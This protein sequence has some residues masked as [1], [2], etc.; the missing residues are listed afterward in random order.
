[1]DQT[2]DTTAP[3]AH[4]SPRQMARQRNGRISAAA[5]PDATA[6]LAARIDVLDSSDRR[7]QISGN[8]QS[9][10]QE[11][12]DTKR[13]GLTLTS[14]HI[15]RNFSIAG[16]MIRKHL[17]FVASHNFEPQTG[18]E[19]LDRELENLV[20]WWSRPENCDAGGR[21]PLCRMVRL[22]EACRTLDGDLLLMKLASGKVQPIEGDRIKTPGVDGV[23]LRADG[24]RISNGVLLGGGDR[25]QAWAVHRRTQYGGLEFERWVPNRNV[26]HHGYF[27]RFDQVRG[28]SPLLGA[29]APLQ[30][31]YE[32]FT[33]ALAK[34]KAAQLF[35]IAF[36][37]EAEETGDLPTEGEDTDG[38][39]VDDRYDVT[40]GTRPLILDLDPGDRA[41]FLENKT[42]ATEFQDFNQAMIG[43][44]LKALDIPYSFYDE[45]YTNFF[46]SMAAQKLYLKSARE[47]RR[48]VQELL[49]KLTVWRL[50][51]FIE[52]GDLRLPG[53]KT[54]ADLRW[55]WIPDG[56]P[57]FRPNEELKAD[58]EAIENHLKTREMVTRERYGTSWRDLAGRLKKENEE[59]VK[60]GLVA[61]EPDQPPP[62]VEGTA[63]E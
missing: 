29:L 51:L 54:L 27:E 35:G 8:V 38:D 14:R 34:S 4:R 44:A 33:Y 31:V 23:Q 60:L 59:L 20:G 12:P 43:V 42:P 52:D 63:D 40:L 45:G 15:V 1:M 25:A 57:W 61:S 32:N 5:W 17:D 39:G 47:K 30:D 13:R 18:D 53:G 11:V 7:Q 16:W 3:P 28:V 50:R 21:H 22:A 62:G 2:L 46:G 48:D 56:L 55:E 36:Y 10:D 6:E 37:R 58:V 41:E 49:R 19:G 9:V 24:S 26:I